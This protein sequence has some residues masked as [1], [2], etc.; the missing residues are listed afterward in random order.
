MKRGTKIAK[1][2]PSKA[3]RRGPVLLQSEPRDS[4]MWVPMGMML[5]AANEWRREG[6]SDHLSAYRSHPI[7]LSV[8]NHITRAFAGLPLG[9]RYVEDRE[10]IRN[11]D[12]LAFL[13]APND[14]ETG[15]IHK[16]NWMSHL[17]LDGN[18]F[19]YLNT[20][21]P[22]DLLE[23]SLLPPGRVDPQGDG[24]LGTITGYK[25]ADQTLALEKIIHAKLC[26]PNGWLRGA[27]PL[28]SAQVLLQIDTESMKFFRDFFK[29]AMAPRGHMEAPDLTPDQFQIALDNLHRAWKRAVSSGVPLLSSGKFTQ[30]G[31]NPTDAGT[32]DMQKWLYYTVCFI[33]GMNPEVLGLP[34]S[35]TY[36]NYATGRRAFYQDTVCPYADNFLEVMNAR[37]LP[38]FGDP[39]EVELYYDLDALDLFAEDALKR[40]QQ[41]TNEVNA[42]IISAD[43]ARLRQKL[44]AKGGAAGELTVPANKVMLDVLAGGG[45]NF[46]NGKQKQLAASNE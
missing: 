26:N 45:D 6:E 16:Q 17:L 32:A 35:K 21:D 37:L 25:Y 19:E 8:I 41:D 44:P 27:S 3:A 29:N 13:R 18:A 14:H 10:D 33:Y 30:I 46:L 28:D 7:V 2:A 34:D 9:V 31:I 12:M 23:M 1:R 43:E 20:N 22:G 38:F 42:G 24:S 11:H 15:S 36:D 5:Y 39:A 4:E 40:R